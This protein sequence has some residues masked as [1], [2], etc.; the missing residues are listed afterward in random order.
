MSQLAAA[1]ALGQDVDNLKKSL[2]EKSNALMLA[3]TKIKDMAEVSAQIATL[4][5][6]LT[7]ALTAKQA[8][9]NKAEEMATSEKNLN[10]SL[11][12]SSGKV[13]A[14]ENELAAAQARIKELT[15]K[16][17]LQAQQDLVPTLNQQIATLRDQITQMESV[18]AQ[19]K[20]SLTEATEKVAT[21][22]GGSPGCR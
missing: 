2:D 17:L 5:N 22:T 3:E 1:Q 16:N 18:S 12:A 21:K 4:E 20:K 13:K 6:K 8:A 11:T 14:L 15:D 19:T 7:A 9:E 10:E